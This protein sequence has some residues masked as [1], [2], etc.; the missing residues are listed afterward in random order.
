M[1][2]AASEKAS[3]ALMILLSLTFKVF[4][5][6]KIIFSTYHLHVSH[7]LYEANKHFQNRLPRNGKTT[8]MFA[9]MDHSQGVLTVGGWVRHFAQTNQ[10]K[11][12]SRF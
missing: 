3:G 4:A 7:V 10:T 1:T 12:V 9:Q 6:A 5:V 8:G 11:I 2:G